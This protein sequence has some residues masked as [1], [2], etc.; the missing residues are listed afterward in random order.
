MP[1]FDIKRF[2]EDWPDA[3]MCFIIKIL[4]K[5]RGKWLQ[6]NWLI[7]EMQIFYKMEHKGSEGRPGRCHH[8]LTKLIQIGYLELDPATGVRTSEDFI[9]TNQQ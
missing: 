6:Y 2:I 4:E 1:N 3:G 7:S 8:N 5:D 9:P